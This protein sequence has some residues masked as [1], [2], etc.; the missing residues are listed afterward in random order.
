MEENQ[1]HALRAEKKANED[2]KRL[3]DNLRGTQKQISACIEEGNDA[4]KDARLA[5]KDNQNGIEAK[6]TADREGSKEA[7][8]DIINILCDS[9]NGQAREATDIIQAGPHETRSLPTQ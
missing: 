4:S 2:T 5:M 3:S 8:N 6:M 9:E 7:Q 1:K